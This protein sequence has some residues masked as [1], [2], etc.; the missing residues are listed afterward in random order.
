MRELRNKTVLLCVGGGIAAYKTCD[1]VRRLSEAGA[2]VEVAMTKAAT[3]FIT[4]LTLQALAQRPVATELLS[5]DQEAQ[6]GHIRLAQRADVVL[7]APATADL[8]AR[9][10]SGLAD[11]VVTAVVLATRAP[12]IVCPSM[13][14]NMLEHPAT[15]RNLERLADFGYRVV[16]PDS[17]DLACGVRGPGRLPDSDVL[18]EEVRAALA[19]Q[20]LAGT[21]VLVSAG[22]TREP[23]DPVRCITNRSSGRTGYAIAAA[24]RRRGA[25][26]TLVSGPV[27]LRPPR[28][29][30]VEAVETAEQMNEAVRRLVADADVVVMVAAVADYRP[31][32]S[33]PQKIKKDKERLTIELERTPDILGGLRELGGQRILVGFAAET[34]NVREQALE[35][36]RRKSLDMIVAN[37]VGRADAGFDAETNAAVIIDRW[38]REEQTGLV[39]KEELAERIL[40]R[41]V[42]LL[43]G[44]PAE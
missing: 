34:E 25:R 21:R 9:L 5:L 1:L 29:C 43:G 44:P 15:R 7:V 38:G 39:A 28:G 26:V 8:I 6:I 12:V 18:V 20:D 31:V 14:T 37:D 3:A 30:Q 22:P 36:L 40:D 23:I 17:G 33:E 41:V 32:R 10:A 16:E 13:N 24:A 2:A 4:P 11:D 27:A 19:P 35:K 42:A